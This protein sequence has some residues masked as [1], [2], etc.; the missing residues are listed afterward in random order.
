MATAVRT[1][2]RRRLAVVSVALERF[3]L[4]HGQ[5]PERLDDLESGFLTDLPTDPYSAGPLNYHRLNQ[6]PP[7]LWSVGANGRD[8]GGRSAPDQDPDLIQEATSEVG[9]LDEVWAR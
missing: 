7:R 4:R 2:S 6:G 5:Y 1:E 9:P 3:R 8:D